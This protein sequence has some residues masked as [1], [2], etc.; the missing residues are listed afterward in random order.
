MER[1]PVVPVNIKGGLL[2]FCDPET[3]PE[4]VPFDSKWKVAIG[5]HPKKIYEASPQSVGRFFE[6]V[7][8]S[9]V[10]AVGEVGLDSSMNPGRANLDRQEQF[11]KEITEW[12]K[13]TMPLIL[14]IRS[15]REDTYSKN[16]YYRALQIFKH[17]CHPDQIFIL[18]CF[19]SDKETIT[20]WLSNFRNTYF[21]F[22]HLITKFNQ[23][24]IQALR[25]IPV[26]RLLA[27]TDAPYMP[28]RGIRINTPIYVGE[29]VEKL[30][31]LRYVD[32]QTMA[33]AT[34]ENA[35]RIF[36]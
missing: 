36:V 20:S 31:T 12:I 9:R 14:H 11:L 5:L 24:Q 3:Y 30:A 7:T 6:Y 15:N 32:L 16:L 21:G 1:P 34:L 25:Y 8:N 23:Q 2:I 33:L 13:P 17:R 22:T 26:N 10:S 35:Q 29:V 28:P 4:T 18:H 19:T 27:E